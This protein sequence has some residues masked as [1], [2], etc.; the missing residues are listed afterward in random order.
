M[1]HPQLQATISDQHGHTITENGLNNKGTPKTTKEKETTITGKKNDK[2][3]GI[4][5][6]NQNKQNP[7]ITIYRKKIKFKNIN[8][9]PG[10]KTTRHQATPSKHKKSI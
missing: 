3:T 8:S 6:T 1:P 5:K 4:L 2:T 10:K 9:K 7:D